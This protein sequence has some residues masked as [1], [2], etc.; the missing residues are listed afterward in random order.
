MAEFG[1]EK[2][3]GYSEKVEKGELGKDSEE[4]EEEED[5]EEEETSG[6]LLTTG[7]CS[8]NGGR[9]TKECSTHFHK[10]IHTYWARSVKQKWGCGVVVAYS[11]EMFLL[12]LHKAVRRK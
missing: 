5:E 12:H 6:N 3:E 4:E 9:Q 7:S 1:E 2:P 11:S 8:G 10:Q